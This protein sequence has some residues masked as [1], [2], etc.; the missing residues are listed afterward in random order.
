MDRLGV[1]V[2]FEGMTDYKFQQFPFIP[3]CYSWQNIGAGFEF[4]VPEYYA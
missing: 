4:V 1:I 2:L 3:L